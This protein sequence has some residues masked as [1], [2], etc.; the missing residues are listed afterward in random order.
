MFFLS[1]WI[2]CY[3]FCLVLLKLNI[4]LFKI[5][6][7]FSVLIFFLNCCYRIKKEFNE[8]TYF[9]EQ[10]EMSKNKTFTWN[11]HTYRTMDSIDLL[12][13]FLT[14]IYNIKV[15]WLRLII[16]L[17][18]VKIIYFFTFF[19][20][21]L[22]FL[23]YIYFFF[24]NILVIL[25]WYLNG[26]YQILECQ[27]SIKYTTDSP[28][29]FFYNYLISSAKA[30]AFFVIYYFFSK[31]NNISY[32]NFD[33]LIFNFVLQA[34]FWYIKYLINL[35]L[36]L[37]EICTSGTFKKK[38][39]KIWIR[40]FFEMFKEE[41]I[42][43]CFLNSQ[44]F[45]LLT[46][47]KRIILTNCLTL[48]PLS[49]GLHDVLQN[50][51]SKELFKFRLLGVLKFNDL[52]HQV[53]YAPDTNFGFIMTTSKDVWINSKKIPTSL[54]YQNSVIQ[55]RFFYSA[56]NLNMLNFKTH[57]HKNF[58]KNNITNIEDYVGFNLR[59][60]LLEQLK[61]SKYIVL[62]TQESNVI[63]YLKHPRSYSNIYYGF[64]PT[65]DKGLSE[66]IDKINS[67]KKIIINTDK[68][69]CELESISNN[70]LY[71]EVNIKYPNLI[72]E[73]TSLTK[74]NYNNLP[75]NNL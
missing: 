11:S 45:V 21:I 36:L 60:S 50:K 66:H 63:K 16:T 13:D 42:F 47:G 70:N 46:K 34:P 28:I 71:T 38:S 3:S 30:H 49:N 57:Y 52:P 10:I 48:N 1:L 55:Q 31:K 18:I 62:Q 4:I 12:F 25:M 35:S 72:T 39:K 33:N 53:F 40:I 22:F 54:L 75:N 17:L 7:L 69:I 6:L 32:K 68:L 19:F 2:K 9:K 27:I 29:T 65:T 58:F 43:S 26:K 8:K 56:F 15:Y 20:P 23:L 59:L 44:S 14:I 24:K 61:T 64:V 37:I 5:L 51:S 73:L 74:S 41:L 67:S